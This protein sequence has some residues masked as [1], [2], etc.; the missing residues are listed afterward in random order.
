M[1][2]R[3]EMCLLLLCS[4]GTKYERFMDTFMNGNREWISSAAREASQQEVRIDLTI[5]IEQ[6][7]VNDTFELIPTLVAIPCEILQIPIFQKSD[8]AIINKG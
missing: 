7:I 2:H 1:Y 6:G 8:T 4:E 3:R 5:N